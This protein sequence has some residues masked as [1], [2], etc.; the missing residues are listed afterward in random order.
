MLTQNCQN[1]QMISVSSVIY[2]YLN[3]CIMRVSQTNGIYFALTNVQ[4]VI[5]MSGSFGYHMKKALMLTSRTVW[6]LIR[7]VINC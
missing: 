1:M 2:K 7:L 6:H 4:D 3:N 5:I